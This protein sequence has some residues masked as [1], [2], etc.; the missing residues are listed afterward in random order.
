MDRRPP[1]TVPDLDEF[2]FR[3]DEAPGA[4]ADLPEEELV[5]E[6]PEEPTREYLSF[7]LADESY[8]L[9]LARVRE[10]AKI[11]PITEVPRA[12]AHV[13]GVMNL[14]G[15]VM[16][17]FD[18]H[19][20]LGLSRQ[21]PSGRA[22]RVVVVETGQGPAALLVDAVDQVIHLRP[23]SIE[24]PPPGLRGVEADYL[25]GIGRAEER[26]VVLLQ[27]E[28]VIGLRRLGGVR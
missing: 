17:V 28:S 22:A 4:A 24:A 10:I 25:E 9:E 1:A 15:E 18:L 16:P 11:L 2:F 3:P 5:E 14:R 6:G 7:R 12:P 19:Q 23:S 20:R 8:A 26:M 27:L 13:L 21:G